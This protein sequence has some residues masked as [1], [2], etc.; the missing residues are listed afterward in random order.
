[1]DIPR[2]PGAKGDADFRLQEFDH[3]VRVAGER[4]DCQPT[5]DAQ[6]ELLSLT[7]DEVSDNGT[8]KTCDD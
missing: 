4:A 1:M 5:S 2:E 6:E 3:R 7:S 8:V